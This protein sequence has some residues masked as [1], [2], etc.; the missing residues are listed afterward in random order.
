MLSFLI[1]EWT[2]FQHDNLISDIHTCVILRLNAYL[3]FLEKNIVT[4]LSGMVIAYNDHLQLKTTSE[5]SVIANLR[6]LKIRF[7]GS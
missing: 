3:A 7:I 5:Y 1:L 4:L 6:T 2:I